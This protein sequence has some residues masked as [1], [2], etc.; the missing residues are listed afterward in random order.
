MPTS[1]VVND[2]LHVFQVTAAGDL[3]HGA[4]AAGSGAFPLDTV[5][6]ECDPKVAPTAETFNNNL[7]VFAQKASGQIVWAVAPHG[8]SKWDVKVLGA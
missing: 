6:N 3:V 4:H 1:L 5:T 7:H 8:G 2:H